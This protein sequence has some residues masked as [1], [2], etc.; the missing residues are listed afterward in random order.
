M[1]IRHANDRFS[2]LPVSLSLS[3]LFALLEAYCL[4]RFINLLCPSFLRMR[5]QLDALRD[6][7]ILRT[8]GL[9]VLDILTIVPDAVPTNV[10]GDYIPFSIGA[11]IV[12]GV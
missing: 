2:F 11:V 1:N 7:R 4:G 6:A 10:L 12:L 3:L 9:L 5:H 8:L